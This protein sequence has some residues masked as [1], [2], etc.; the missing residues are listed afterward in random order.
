MQVPSGFTTGLLIEAA[1]EGRIAV[2]F[3]KDGVLMG[4]FTLSPLDVA[5]MAAAMLAASKDGAGNLPQQEGETQSSGAIVT[6]SSFSLG[7]GATPD[8]ESLILSF[9]ESHL[10]FSMPQS[11]MKSLGEGMVTL[12]T[13]GR[14][15]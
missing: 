6:P 13:R 11:A 9:G 12:A 14:A 15:R 8:Q 1:T 7:P 4:D 2:G 5:N 3:V 10:V